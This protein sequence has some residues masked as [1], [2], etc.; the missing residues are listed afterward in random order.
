MLDLHELEICIRDGLLG[1]IMIELALEV[2][3]LY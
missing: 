2:T 1:V 3:S